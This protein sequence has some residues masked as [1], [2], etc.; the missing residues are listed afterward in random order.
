MFRDSQGSDHSGV[1]DFFFFLL[2]F[3]A[4]D[5]CPTLA[6]NVKPKSL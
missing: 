6:I 5:I 2:T 3:A 4:G 1:L